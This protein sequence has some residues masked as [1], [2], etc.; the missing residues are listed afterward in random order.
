[1]VSNQNKISKLLSEEVIQNLKIF[2][3]TLL[4]N[5]YYHLAHKEFTEFSP[6]KKGI[7]TGFSNTRHGFFF[8]EKDSL[9]QLKNSNP[10]VFGNIEIKVRLDVRKPLDL[11][12][13]SIFTK[14]DQASTIWEAFT[15]EKVTNQ[16]AIE[17]LDD[18]IG[19]GEIEELRD[20][21]SRA[22]ALR[23]FR[24]NGYDGII[25]TLGGDHKE[26]V[27]F[28]P[29]QIQILSKPALIKAYC[30]GKNGFL[31]ESIDALFKRQKR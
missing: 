27:A 12:L 15:S 30:D 31:I 20:A 21:L 6:K 14:V 7:N 23:I 25:N 18:E 11:T 1:M 19:L 22:T 24:R 8:T 4:P 9:V 17:L 28:K 3:E 26:Y 10:G 2:K 5:I 13:N 29:E 16:N